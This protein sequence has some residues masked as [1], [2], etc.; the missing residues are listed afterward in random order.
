MLLSSRDMRIS[1]ISP[2]L[3]TCLYIC[4]TLLVLCPPLKKSVVNS[5]LRIFEFE[6]AKAVGHE[7]L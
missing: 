7:S 3:I 5:L 2:T 4:K 6:V 1:Q